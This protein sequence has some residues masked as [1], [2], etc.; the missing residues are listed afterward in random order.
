MQWGTFMGEG[1]RDGAIPS[2][3]DAKIA[4]VPAVYG[5]TIVHRQRA[6]FRSPRRAEGV[7]TLFNEGG[8]V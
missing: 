4:A 1:E 3:D 6:R 7:L 2:N 5:L 8:F